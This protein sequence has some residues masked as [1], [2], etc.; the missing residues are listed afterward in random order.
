MIKKFLGKPHDPDSSQTGQT[1]RL[2]TSID[3]SGLSSR[4]GPL[5]DA[6][7]ER[8]AARVAERLLQGPMADRVARVVA[9]VAERLVREEIDRIR[10]AARS[11]T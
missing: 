4:V 7:V 11:K 5:S 9:D 10:A 8:I 6:D 3:T 2:V 1:G